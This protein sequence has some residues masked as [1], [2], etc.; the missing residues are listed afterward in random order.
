MPVARIADALSMQ[1]QRNGS[2]NGPSV[3][4]LHQGSYGAWD[5]RESDSP[6]SRRHVSSAVRLEGHVKVFADDAQ[7]DVPIVL[8]DDVSADELHPT[9]A[10]QNRLD[11][12]LAAT[13]EFHREQVL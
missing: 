4:L 1:P 6:G 3:S 9:A 12:R 11:E 10:H 7:S 8:R 2:A 13:I 5:F